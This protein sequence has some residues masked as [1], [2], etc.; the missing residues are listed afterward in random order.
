MLSGELVVL[1]VLV[2]G[3]HAEACRAIIDKNVVVTGKGQV[4]TE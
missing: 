1:V 2:V 3:R 4:V